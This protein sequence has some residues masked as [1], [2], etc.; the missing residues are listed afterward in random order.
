MTQ[1][2]NTA[3]ATM[4]REEEKKQ[5]KAIISKLPAVTLVQCTEDGKHCMDAKG[6]PISDTL[7]LSEVFKSF[8]AMA[9]KYSD[10]VH[11]RIN[12]CTVSFKKGSN[13]GNRVKAFV[14]ELV[15]VM[16]QGKDGANF[17]T[18]LRA[19]YDFPLSEITAEKVLQG[20]AVHEKAVSGLKS[21][22]KLEV[23]NFGFNPEKRQ[24]AKDCASVRK[25]FK[26]S[27]AAG[28]AALQGIDRIQAVKLI[29]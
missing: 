18:S 5:V 25:E 19:K 7:Q 9:D 24:I 6:Q 2:N 27:A 10:T 17:C 12:G 1:N 26:Q 14:K 20:I 22:V 15:P 23:N 28:L 8:G 21:L 29:S 16:L 11:F 3:L 4:T 13:A